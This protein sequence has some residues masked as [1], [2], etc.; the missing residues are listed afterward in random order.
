MLHF[1]LSGGIREV[2]ATGRSVA[3]K[4]GGEVAGVLLQ[5]P[6]HEECRCNILLIQLK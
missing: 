2:E 1:C 4:Q 5:V 6:F 3:V